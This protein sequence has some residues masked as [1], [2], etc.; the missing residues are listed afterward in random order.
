[1]TPIRRF[2]PATPT[3]PDKF[4]DENLRD[5]FSTNYAGP[6]ATMP[7]VNVK[8]T[9]DEFQIEVAAPGMKKEDFSINLDNNMLSISSEHKEE[10][11]DEDEGYTRKE[12]SYQSF[13]RTFNIPEGVID[14]EKIDA[15]YDDGILSIRMPKQEEAKVKPAKK[16][17][18]K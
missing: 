2:I 15:K 9:D 4:L 18:I 13:R 14:Q 6:K 17:D 5:I 1:M 16:I 12:F 8:E 7:S 11:K 10:A 3:S